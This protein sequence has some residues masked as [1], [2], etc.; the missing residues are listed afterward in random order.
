MVGYMNISI[1]TVYNS[2]NYGSFLQAYALKTYLES[3]GHN[4]SFLETK[5]RNPLKQTI[6]STIKKALKLDIKGARFQ[7]KKYINF[8][9]VIKE[10]KLCKNNESSLNSQDIFIFGSDEIWNIS[11]EDFRKYPIFMGVGIKNKRLISY[12]PS[13]NTTKIE[14]INQNSYV[15]DALNRFDKISVRDNY[16]YTTLKNVIEKDMEIVLDPTFL[17]DKSVYLQTEHSVNND[18]YILVYSYGH[19]M[20]EARVKRIKEFAKTKNLKLLSVGFDLEWCDECVSVSPFGFLS[21][22]KNAKYIITDT[23]HGTVFSIIYNKN[24]VTYGENNTKIGEI[25][26]QFKINS[27]NIESNMK[28]EDILNENIDYQSVNEMIE[29]YKERSI[30]YINESINYNYGRK[31]NIHENTV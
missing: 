11:R 31:E 28:L 19:N 2:L 9:K 10:F 6:R 20:N 1:V 17:I 8:D 23:F 15:K 13:I 25:T 7:V 18:E 30:K 3:L 22:I 4:V 16:S 26:N 29:I 14:V 5:A 24:F 27:R 12:A 21:Y